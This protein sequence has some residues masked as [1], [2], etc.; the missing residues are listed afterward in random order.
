MLG[1]VFFLI[2]P[3]IARLMPALPP[4][5]ITGPETFYRF[6]YGVLI[7]FALTTALALALAARAPKHGRPWLVLAGLLIAHAAVFQTVGQTETWQR[8]FVSLSDVP[9]PLLVSIGFAV[10]IAATWAGWLAGTSPQRRSA[11]AA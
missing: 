4:L 5:A 8:L 3:I 10:S 2:P 1:T 9:V 7:A 11:A 6:A